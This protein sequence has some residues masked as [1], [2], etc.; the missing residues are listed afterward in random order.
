MTKIP[1]LYK[2][3]TVPLRDFYGT[4]TTSRALAAILPRIEVISHMWF[5]KATFGWDA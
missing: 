1:R 2:K 4:F 3:A 5:C